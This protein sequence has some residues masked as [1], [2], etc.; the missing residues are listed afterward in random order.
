MAWLIHLRASDVLGGD[1]TAEDAIIKCKYHDLLAADEYLN[2]VQSAVVD[3]SLSDSAKK[4]LDESGIPTVSMTLLRD[5]L[6]PVQSEYDLIVI[7]VPPS[8]GNLTYMSLVASTDL[9][10]PVEASTYGLIGALDLNKT[11]NSVKQSYNPDLNVVGFALTRYSGSTTLGSDVRG[12]FRDW[13]EREGYYLFNSTVREA[14]IIRQ[15]Q[16]MQIPLIDHAP[17]ANVTN[18][19]LD[20]TKELAERLGL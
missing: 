11:I 15:A 1:C 18:D 14:T 3:A 9:L 5:K 2:N 8:L 10:C 17:K 4:I 13:C 12:M 20:L 7:D 16:M 19:Y 6:L